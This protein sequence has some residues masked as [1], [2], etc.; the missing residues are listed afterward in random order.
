MQNSPARH[1][2]YK[3]VSGSTKYLLYCA[4]PWVENKL[5]AEHMSEVSPNVIKLINTWTL[6][7][8]SK[9]PTYKSDTNV[10]DAMQDPLMI[11]KLTFFSFLCGLVEPVWV[12]LAG[13][14]GWE[15][16][17]ISQTFA[18]SPPPG[19]IPH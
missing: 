16:P 7:L 18:Y 3:S 1:E 11:S 14:M 12:V 10:C 15:S 2:G 19:E 4:P 17:P 13:G 9:Q 8:K 5:V 6:L